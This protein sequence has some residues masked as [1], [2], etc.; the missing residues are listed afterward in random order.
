MTPLQ[1][2]PGY[3]KNILIE[4]I[5]TLIKEMIRYPGQLPKINYSQQIST[6]L[7]YDYTYLANIFSSVQGITIQQFIISS[8]I[9]WAQ[10]LLIYNRLNL[11]EIASKLQYSSV[12]HL[13]YQFKKVTGLTPSCFKALQQ[14]ELLFPVK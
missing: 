9:K 4:R 3:K 1:K 6:K 13:S 2:L 5:H 8:K 11:T 12:A 10:E 14:K 7:N